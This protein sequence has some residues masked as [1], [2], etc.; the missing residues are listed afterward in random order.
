MITDPAQGGNKPL[1]YL[2]LM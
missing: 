1:S 2:P